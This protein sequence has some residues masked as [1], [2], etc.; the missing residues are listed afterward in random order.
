M[1]KHGPDCGD[2]LQ[3]RVDS[4][5]VPQRR[6][7]PPVAR[8]EEGFGA[9]LWTQLAMRVVEEDLAVRLRALE[10][11]RD[12]GKKDDAKQPFIGHYEGAMIHRIIESCSSQTAPLGSGVFDRPEAGAPSSK[13]GLA[14]VCVRLVGKAGEL[15]LNPEAWVRNGDVR[16]CQM[17][18]VRHRA[19]HALFP[20]SGLV[21]GRSMSDVWHASAWRACRASGASVLRLS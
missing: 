5:E 10:E 20:G 13:W 6:I 3:A 9:V 21:N 7:H 16:Q 19:R 18:Q 1:D 17:M 8:S 15:C 4:T 12:K 14:A 2:V 11:R